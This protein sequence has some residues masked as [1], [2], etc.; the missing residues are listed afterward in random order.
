MLLNM[1]HIC[2]NG[3]GRKAEKTNRQRRR[4]DVKARAR[5]KARGRGRARAKAGV[6]GEGG[7]AERVTRGM[8]ETIEVALPMASAT[9]VKGHKG[10]VNGAR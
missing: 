10:V 9:P 4:D 8:L 5:A 3:R 1:Y 2:R 6:G 7:R